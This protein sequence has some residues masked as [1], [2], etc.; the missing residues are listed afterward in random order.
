M[1]LVSVGMPVYNRLPQ[2][3]RA[4]ESILNQTYKNLEIIISNDCSPNPEMYK[5]LDEYASKDSRIRLFHQPIDL[6]CYG[7]YWF[8]QKTATGKYFMYG[9]DDDW[10]EPEFIELLVDN[11][12]KNPENAFALSRSRYVDED[13]KLWQEFR[14]D[15]QG[16]IS[17]IYGE[18]SPFVWMGVWRL[19]R[20]REFD[21]T[22]AD[23]HGKDIIVA[24]E[25]LLS[26]PFGYVDKLLYSKTLYHEKA[27]KYVKDKPWCHFEMYGN[28]LYRVAIS[29]HVKNRGWLVILIP[30][31][32]VAIVRLYAA[33]VLFLLPIDHPI[34]K[35]VRKVLT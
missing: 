6:E 7:N 25:S 34:R 12:E 8:V 1:P 30:A 35:A 23:V 27:Q 22:G 11:L 32:C 13:G 3:K 26:Y 17:F 16:T 9:Q 15:D 21:Y 2:T 24:A 28:L 14:F 19:D 20:L 4:I 29:K 31:S 10:W 5:M 33:Q 18:K